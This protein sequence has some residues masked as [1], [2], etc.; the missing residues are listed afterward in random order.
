MGG[1]GRG[2]Y[3]DDRYQRGGGKRT[4]FRLIVTNLPERT[5]YVGV[6]VVERW[7][8]CDPA[9][10]IYIYIY[11]PM[12]AMNTNPYNPLTA[13]IHPSVPH[14]NGT[15]KTNPQNN[16]WQDLKDFFRPIGDVGFTDVDQRNGEGV[17]EFM[18]KVHTCIHTCVGMC[19]DP[20]T[21]RP[22]V[23]SRRRV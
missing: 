8:A 20:T 21:C 18:Y 11:T 1:G 6:G 9:R 14:I 3:G 4:D 15:T 12:Y 23:L 16:S 5:R 22:C 13:P 17:V 19:F 10:F 7:G 2:G